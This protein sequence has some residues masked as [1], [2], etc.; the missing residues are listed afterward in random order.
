MQKNKV[1][2][3]SVSEY[4]ADVTSD[5]YVTVQKGRR[6]NLWLLI[7]AIVGI[8]NIVVFLLTE[9]MRNPMIL[10]DK[11]TI[12]NA[13]LFI[14]EIIAITL[15]FQ[16]KKQQRKKQQRKTTTTTNAVE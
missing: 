4:V 15:I 16:R 12:V 14:A 1:Y 6:R 3:S 13:V 5:E 9:N 11:W 2:S 10:V 8:V 7:A